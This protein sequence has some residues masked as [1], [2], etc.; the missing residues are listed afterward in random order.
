MTDQPMSG[1]PFP[2]E[3]PQAGRT[4]ESADVVVVGGG[5]AGLVAA[6]A[7]ARNGR[8]VVLLEAGAEVGGTVA[9][10]TVDGITVDVGAE[11][12]ATRR[13]TVSALLTDLGLASDVVLPDPAGAWVQ[14]PGQA[15]PLPR[16]GLLGIPGDP[17]DPALRE[18]LG[19]AG[20]VRAA[21]DLVLP[22]S[23]GARAS[24]LGELVRARMGRRVLDRLVAPVVSGVHSAHPDDVDADVVAPGLRAGVT[25]EGSLAASVKRLRAL[26]PAGSAVAGIAGGMH[27]LTAV[28]RHDVERRGVRILTNAPVSRVVR[29]RD[30]DGAVSSDQWHVDLADGRSFEPSRVLV[31]VP[32]AELIRIFGAAIPSRVLDGWPAASSVELVTLVVDASAGSA[33]RAGLDAAPRGTGVLVAPGAPGVRAKALTHMTA[34]WRWLAESAGGKHVMRLS[35]GRAGEALPRLSDDALRQVAIEDASALLGVPLDDGQVTGFARTRWTNT[36]PFAARG[37]RARV[38]AVRAEVAQQPGLE[39]SG[40]WIAGTGLASV[41]ADA[42]AAAARL[43]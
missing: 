25:S 22:A 24:S 1:G 19:W 35:Y 41:V 30:L 20:A 14:L 15:I 16:T 10:A 18:T 29:R 21:L 9:A 6:R 34:K 27:R 12:F 7:L 37:Q 5:V 11:S 40:A 17:R 23:V 4:P 33:T 2:D 13:G 3:H 28:L 32:V 36:V 38:A 43:A 26:A 31:A 39:V 8:S 42:E